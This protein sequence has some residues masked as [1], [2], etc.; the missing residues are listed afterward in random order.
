VLVMAEARTRGI[1]RCRAAVVPRVDGASL[2]STLRA[3]I[4]AGSVLR[5][6]GLNVLGQSMDGFMERSLT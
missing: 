2:R 4:E 3:K 6:D 5:S 1:G